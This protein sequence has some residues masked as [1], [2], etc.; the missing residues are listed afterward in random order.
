M[1]CVNC[2]GEWTPPSE[3]TVTECPFCKT[4]VESSKKSKTY[5]NAKEALLF[6]LTNHGANSLLTKNLFSDIAPNLRDERELIK[7]FRE[8]GALEILNG[9]LNS[10]PS[11]QSLAIK[12]ATAKLPV[13][14][15]NSPEAVS[16]L[17]DFAEVLGWKLNTK[18][19]SSYTDVNDSMN[20]QECYHK[21]RDYY[22][23]HG[24]VQD[25]AI[26]TKWY[27]KSAD[28]GYAAALYD[29]GSM[30]EDGIGVIQNYAESRKMYL[31][32]AKLG[33]EIA[34]YRLSL[35]KYE[36]NRDATIFYNENEL[37]WYQK[38][39]DQGYAL[40]QHMLGFLY[41]TGIVLPKDYAK[42]VEWLQKAAKQGHLRALYTLGNCYYYGEGVTKDISKS[43]ELYLKS[44]EQGLAIAQNGIGICYKNGEGVPQDYRKAME[45]LRKSAEQGNPLAQRNLGSMYA[46][47]QG[48]STDDAKAAEWYLKSAEAENSIAQRIMGALYT[49]GQGVPQNFDKAFGWYLKAAEQ[50]DADAQYNL[51]IIYSTGR[52]VPAD[53]EK[54]V[55]WYEKAV[56]QGHKEAL[57]ELN[58]TTKPT[59]QITEGQI[60]KCSFCGA[61]QN[62]VEKII[63]GPSVYICNSCV[64]AC[65]DILFGGKNNVSHINDCTSLYHNGLIFRCSF[66]GKNRKQVQKLVCDNTGKTCVCNE[67]AEMCVVILNETEATS[68]QM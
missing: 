18:T 50:G 5:D 16:L 24:V 30:Y 40:A 38:M 25:Y 56:D 54:A 64:Q 43:A 48:V 68:Q 11:E 34:Q 17:N 37:R 31:S 45:W 53:Y 7:M 44:A 28:Q 47:G 49:D 55:L 65:K 39:A 12:R 60:C 61:S 62:D 46:N 29:L 36:V 27:K 22:Y 23:G 6:I 20:A 19:A 51:G 58:R 4:P 26:A 57:Q 41:Y 14:F 32:A 42:A 59:E 3:I 33:Y 10:L 67:C 1:K 21:G 15:Q 35:K 2:K 63:A 66:C 13:Y 9:A 8:K 52:G